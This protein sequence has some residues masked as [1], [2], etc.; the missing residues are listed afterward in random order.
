MAT[1]KEVIQEHTFRFT[2]RRYGRQSYCWAEV[3]LPNGE[4]K[5]LGDPWPGVNW[6]KKALA[7]SVRISMEVSA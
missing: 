6:P 7:E 4:W 3:L 1:T 2:R 5:D